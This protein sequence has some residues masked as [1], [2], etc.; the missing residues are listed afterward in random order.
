MIAIFYIAL[1]LSVYIWYY[2]YGT[3][4]ENVVRIVRIVRIIDERIN[5]SPLLF[6]PHVI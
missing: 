4:C 1:K 5:F 6:T 2:R 3:N